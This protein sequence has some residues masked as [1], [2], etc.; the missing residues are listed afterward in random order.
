MRQLRLVKNKFLNVLI[1]Y[2]VFF[3]V[4]MVIEWVPIRH[5]TLNYLIHIAYE[6]AL[7]LGGFLILIFIFH[8]LNLLPKK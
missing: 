1:G 8:R 7:A 6:S 5:M 2:A 4:M 3:C